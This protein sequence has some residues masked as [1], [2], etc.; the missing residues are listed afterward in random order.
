MKLRTKILIWLLPI[1]LPL[2]GYNILQYEYKEDELKNNINHLSLITTTASAKELNNYLL[3]SLSSFQNISQQLTR[4]NINIDS[5]QQQQLGKI[6]ASIHINPFFS[7]FAFIGAEGQI[8]YAQPSPIKSNRYILPRNI[9]GNR[10]LTTE[11]IA[12][13]TNHSKE[14]FAQKQTIK[15]KLNKIQIELAELSSEGQLNS[16]RYRDLQALNAKFSL[17]TSHLPPYIFLGAANIA[18]KAGL[19]F[20]KNSLVF[21]QP[22]FSC[23]QE[24]SG[25]FSAVLDWTVVEDILFKHASQLNSQ[26]LS[27]AE[28]F[29]YAEDKQQALSAVSQRVESKFIKSQ[30]SGNSGFCFSTE[31][32]VNCSRIYDSF[33]LN[34]P[35]QSLKNIETLNEYFEM[36]KLLQKSVYHLISYIPNTEMD[37]I[38]HKLQVEIVLW[39]LVTIVI[40][41]ILILIVANKITSPVRVLCS[42]MNDLA[43]GESNARSNIQLEDEIGDLSKHFNEMA[44]SIQ[45]QKQTLVSNLALLTAVVESTD[46]GILVVDE[47]ETS[48]LKNDR[49]SKLWKIPDALFESNDDNAMIQYVLEQLS[50]PDEFLHKVEDLYADRQ[51]ISEDL[52]FFKDGRTFERYSQPYL[53][54]GHS[55]GRVWSFRDITERK[56][57]EQHLEELIDERTSQLQLAKERE[58]FWLQ[59]QQVGQLGGWRAN[60]VENTVMW[61]NGI[62]EIVEMSMGY[63]PDLETGLDFYLPDSRQRIVEHLQ[64][65]LTTGIP[66]KIQVQVKARRSGKI[67]WTELR[68]EAHRNTDGHIDYL[69]GTLQDISEQKRIAWE[70]EHHKNHLQEL[71]DEKTAELV[72]ANATKDEFL[73]NMSHEIRTPMNAII[74]MSHL[75]LQTELNDKQRNYITKVHYSADRLLGI[76]NDILDISKIEAGKLEL[77]EITFLLKHVIDNMFNIIQLKANEVGVKLSIKIDKNVPR[78]LLGDPLRL[79]QVLIN[80]AN[81]AVKFSPSGATVTF[82]I[83][84]KEEC[85][86]NVLLHFSIQDTGLGIS[87]EQQERLFQPFNQLD[88]STTR[89]YGGTGLGLAISKNITQLMSGDIWVDSAEGKGST[90]HFTA[91]LKKAQSNPSEDRSNSL[92]NAITQLKGANILL[93]E[94]NEINQELAMEL[95]IINGMTVETADNGQLALDLL[96]KKRFDGVLMDCM[97]PVMDGYEATQKIRAQNTLKNL[98]IIA[99]TANAMKKDVEKVLSVGMNDHIAKPINPDTM[100]IT[101]A[102]WIKQDA[103]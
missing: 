36:D 28:V 17:I 69:M 6:S 10:L 32:L 3:R 27:A 43:N 68:G 101:M 12:Q 60:P 66:F 25:Y 88:S 11:Q 63:K 31:A 62:Y 50:N 45:K 52:L 21:I 99:M 35:F 67:K 92:D 65:T 57:A 89:Q 22:L 74:G 44:D 33:V 76:I 90:F 91:Q 81:N 38:I 56:Q 71:V 98:P 77:E 48:I 61:T 4:C 15:S 84:L 78:N 95:L 49:F 42:V 37:R 94:D 26:K 87:S 80:L 75:A 2:L 39:T 47:H 79:G 16:K 72:R 54:K 93:V 64:Q 29:I 9:E 86:D 46:N 82:K 23:Q 24:I 19:P 83:S 7:L 59:S 40:L 5:V 103:T 14:W 30:K 20:N 96:E 18:Q 34:E 1:L 58:F 100:L 70:L 51:A 73:A 97:M 55:S 41:I 8:T 85:K 102:K 53:I 13:L